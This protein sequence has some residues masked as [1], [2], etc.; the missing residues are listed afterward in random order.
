MSDDI[1]VEDREGRPIALVEVKA[2]VTSREALQECLQRFLDVPDPSISFGLLVD[3][4]NIH[5]LKR[6]TQKET[7]VPVAE[8]NTKDVL[9]YYA[10]EFAG[11]DSRYVG[12]P[13]FLDY[14]ETLV[15]GWL[16]DLAY[17]WKSASP[18][19]AEALAGTG[20]LERIKEGMTRRTE[21]AA[22]GHSLS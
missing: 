13:M 3:L 16:R 10:P 14:V 22:G 17:H 5:L 20:L 7:F 4:E 1:I 15:E 12:S 9:G 19:G 6:D 21:E 2:S 18:P 11:N 8:L